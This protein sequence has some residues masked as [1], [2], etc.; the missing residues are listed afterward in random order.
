MEKLKKF[1]NC[2]QVQMAVL[3]VASSL[4]GTAIAKLTK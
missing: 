4:V 3:F 1:W 2:R